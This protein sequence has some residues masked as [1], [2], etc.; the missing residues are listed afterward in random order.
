MKKRITILTSVLCILALIV[1]L[2]GCSQVEAPLK[3]QTLFDNYLHELFVQEVKSDSLSLNYSLA[4]PENYGITDTDTT[5]GEYSVSHML[6]DLSASENYLSR[7]LSFDYSSLSQSQKLTYDILKDYLLQNLSLGNYTYYNESLSPTTGIQAQLPILLAEYSFYGKKDIEEYL[8]LLPCVYDYFKDIAQ[9]EREKSKKG[10]FMRDEVADQIIAQC[11]A[12]IADPG[13]NFLIT[14]FNE[15]ITG[16]KGLTSSEIS[17]Y[18]ALNKEAVIVYVIPAY[19]LLIRTLEELKGTGTNN[20]GLYYYPEGQAYYECLAKYKTGSGRTMPQMAEL[21]ETA[22]DEGIVRLTTL[23]IKDPSIID[24]YYAFNSFPIT[25]PQRIIADLKRDIK[26]DFPEAAPVQCN[27]KYVPESLADYLSPA[28]YLTP[29][30]DNYKKNEIYINGNDQKTLSMIYTTV[31][32]EGYPGHLYQCVYFRSQNPSPIRNVM[33]F[34]GYDEGWAT[35]VEMYSYHISG[36]DENLASFLEANN[37]IIL[38]MYAR[39]DIGIHYEG[40]KEKE[41]VAY[42]TNFISDEAKAKKIYATLLEEPAIYLPYAVGY[43]EIMELRKQA[44]DHLQ[45]RFV[46]KDF[47]KFLLD[48]GPAPFGIIQDQLDEW[49]AKKQK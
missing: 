38:C 18:K 5:L 49:L 25:D 28:M 16:Y 45:E 46:A 33:N 24:K 27:I 8:E 42:V 14:Y 35:Y 34:T 12:F 41:V 11:Q 17:R 10:L 31:A 7:L 36:I 6:Q 48:I 47:H 19:E 29:P 20:A 4:E 26:K 40:W 9:F 21:L 30:M 15:K 23:T 43:L 39:A 22:I 1:S 13:S 32:H 3:S 44:K 37:I 2:A